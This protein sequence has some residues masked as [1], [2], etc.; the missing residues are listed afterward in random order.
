MRLWTLLVVLGAFL[1]WDCRGKEGPQGPPGPQGPSGQDLTRI[2]EGYIRGTVKGRDTVLNQNF[3]FSFDYTYVPVWSGYPGYW[4]PES[5]QPDTIQIFFAREGEMGGSLSIDLRH[6]RSTN[7]TWVDYLS[8]NILEISGNNALEYNLN[9][10]SSRDTAYVTGFSLRGD[11][12]VSGRL[13]YIKRSKPIPDTLTA[14]FSSRLLRVISYQRQGQSSV[15]TP[16][17]HSE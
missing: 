5:G 1:L 15:H 3:Q 16:Q 9:Y 8:A 17:S 6:R 4:M 10:S 12:L 7:T 2:R 11:S 14:E 13:T